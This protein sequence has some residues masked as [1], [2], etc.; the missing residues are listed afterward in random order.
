MLTN[1]DKCLGLL[2]RWGSTTRSD[3][4]GRRRGRKKKKKKSGSEDEHKDKM[5]LRKD[6]D[7]P[8][9]VLLE[10]IGLCT[11][12]ICPPPHPKKS[13]KDAPNLNLSPEF[14]LQFPSSSLPFVPGPTDMHVHGRTRGFVE[15][16][17]GASCWRSKEN[18]VNN[19]V[20]SS[21]SN[22]HLRC[23]KVSW[24]TVLSKECWRPSFLQNTKEI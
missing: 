5:I 3:A 22:L 7:E 4:T 16:H 23:F 13:P 17:K 19:L 12:Q 2:F 11:L 24:V 1:R 15:P 14:L 20:L 6:R 10:Q 21:C 8:L 18:L 9:S